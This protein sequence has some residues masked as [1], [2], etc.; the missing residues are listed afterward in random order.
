[1]AVYKK[2]ISGWEAYLLEFKKK[3]SS[4]E[5]TVDFALTVNRNLDLNENTVVR[6]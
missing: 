6:F 1:M 5:S 2:Q 4:V 3:F